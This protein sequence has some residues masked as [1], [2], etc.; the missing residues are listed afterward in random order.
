VAGNFYGV[1]PYEGRYDA[2]QP[3]II[4]FNK[5]TLTFDSQMAL[6]DFEG[7]PRDVEWISLT[8]GRKALIIARNNDELTFVQPVQ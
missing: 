2:L 3:T 7:E 4:S 8:N 1:T 6:R 5:E